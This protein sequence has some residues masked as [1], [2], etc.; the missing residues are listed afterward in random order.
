MAVREAGGQVPGGVASVE[1]QTFRVPA[2]E[3]RPFP[4]SRRTGSSNRRIQI[5]FSVSK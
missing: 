1:R 2:R 5:Q 3:L 4:A